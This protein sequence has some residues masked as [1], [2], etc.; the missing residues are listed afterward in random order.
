MKYLTI[1]AMVLLLAIGVIH[2]LSGNDPMAAI[3]FA[4]AFLLGRDSVKD[5]NDS[6]TDA[7]IEHSRFTI[8]LAER[9]MRGR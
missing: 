8:S 9:I 4:L 5:A 7:V 1:V 2:S 6:L 3:T